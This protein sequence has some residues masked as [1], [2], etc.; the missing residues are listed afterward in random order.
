MGLDESTVEVELHA[1]R[2]GPSVEM[3]ADEPERDRVQRP[4]HLGVG[5]GPHLG[6]GPAGKLEG[7]NRQGQEGSGLIG[8]EH[9]Q[10]CAPLQCSGSPPPC[11]L[12]YAEERVMP[13]WCRGALWDKDFALRWS[14]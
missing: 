13:S 11:H 8:A 7:H 3:G 2:G 6:A 1:H 5:V 9:R 4:A 10:G 14:A 12:H